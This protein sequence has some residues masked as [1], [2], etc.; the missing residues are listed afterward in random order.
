MT[1]QTQYRKPSTGEYQK[2]YYQIP[3]CTHDRFASFAPPILLKSRITLQV[4]PY[5]EVGA[6]ELLPDGYHCYA[7]RDRVILN[8]PGTGAPSTG[9]QTFAVATVAFG[10]KYAD[11]LSP[12]STLRTLNFPVAAASWTSGHVATSFDNS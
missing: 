12:T 4:R 10:S 8:L 9:N 2:R 11:V 7:E 1:R 5:T 3:N 6:P